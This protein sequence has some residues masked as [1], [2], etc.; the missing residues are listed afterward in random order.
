M[1]VFFKPNHLND[2]L[3]RLQIRSNHIYILFVSLLNIISFKTV[4]NGVDRISKTLNFSVRILLISSGILSV[5]AF[6]YE[7]TGVISNRILTL[8]TVILSLTA[9][10]L[11]LVNELVIRVKKKSI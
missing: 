9:V 1:K 2:H 10:G 5:I 4:I 11:F 8:I 3:M 6:M 7:H